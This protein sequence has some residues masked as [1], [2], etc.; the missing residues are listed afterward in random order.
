MRANLAVSRAFLPDLPLPRA[1]LTPGKGRQGVSSLLRPDQHP[2]NQHIVRHDGTPDILAKTW[3]SLPVAAIQTKGPFQPGN[4]GFDAGAEV[5]Q[6]LV[7]PK[8]FDHIQ[9]TQASLLG[10]HHVFDPLVFGQPQV[11]PGGKTAVRRQLPRRSLKRRRLQVQQG[12]KHSGVRRIAPGDQV[13]ATF[14]P[15]ATQTVSRFPLSL[16]W[17]YP[18]VKLSSSS[19]VVFSVS[20]PHQWFAAARLPEPHLPRSLAMTCP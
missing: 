18:G 12:R 10:E 16:S 17:V 8:A 6:L 2:Q 15:D 11:F 14:M 4:I 19:D 9:N 1:N 5:P 13:H 3:P 7:N 20:T